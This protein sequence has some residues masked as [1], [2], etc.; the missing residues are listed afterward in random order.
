MSIPSIPELSGPGFW[1]PN[2]NL[3]SGDLPEPLQP[4]KLSIARL[5]V[6]VEVPLAVVRAP[7]RWDTRWD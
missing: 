1:S 2:G 5:S 6:V 3:F 4:E 7:K